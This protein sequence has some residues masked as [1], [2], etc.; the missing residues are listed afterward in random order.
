M[1]QTE[2]VKAALTRVRGPTVTEQRAM[3]QQAEEQQQREKAEARAAKKQ[4]Q[5]PRAAPAGAIIEESAGTVTGRRGRAL[6][7]AMQITVAGQDGMAALVER[8][9]SLMAAGN[10]RASTGG[11]N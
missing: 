4:Q 7:N 10:W 8:Q 9:R 5:L 6:A 11:Q 2:A 1:L 3:Q